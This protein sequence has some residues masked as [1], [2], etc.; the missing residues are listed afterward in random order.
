MSTT[1]TAASAVTEIAADIETVRTAVGGIDKI[2]AGLAAIEQ[3]YPKD[4]IIGDIQTT[5]GMAKAIEARAAWRDPRIAVEKARKA[6][7]APVLALGKAIDGFAFGLEAKLRAGEEHY[8]AQIKAEEQR[9]AAEKAERDRIERERVARHEQGWPTSA[10]TWTGLLGRPWPRS[11]WR[12]RRED[13]LQRPARRP[14][15]RGPRGRRRQGVLTMDDVLCS[16]LLAALA[17]F[18]TLLF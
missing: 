4:V 14:Q 17:V 7:K 11:W 15:A 5:K 8:D 12:D 10:P 18:A 2:A 9:K 3:A 16:I 13:G 6:A 1:S